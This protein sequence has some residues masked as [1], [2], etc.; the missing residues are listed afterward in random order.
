MTAATTQSTRA[1]P[2]S[3]AP[4]SANHFRALI[5]EDALVLKLVKR[6]AFDVRCF[7]I[8]SRNSLSRSPSAST[9]ESID[10]CDRLLE[11]GERHGSRRPG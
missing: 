5:A 4:A 11:V 1:R 3:P 9:T 8:L 2:S 7:S 6:V 10:G